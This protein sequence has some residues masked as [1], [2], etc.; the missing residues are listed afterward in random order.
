ME[1]HEFIKV[2]ESIE[3]IE[4]LIDDLYKVRV[5]IT[6]SSVLEYGVISDTL[7]EYVYGQEGAD[8]INWWLYERDRNKPTESQCWDENG[9]LSINTVSELYNFIESNYSRK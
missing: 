2:I 6:N 7:W 1:E 5:D 8:W 3:K 4:K 9:P